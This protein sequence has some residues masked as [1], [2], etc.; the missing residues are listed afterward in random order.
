M[1]IDN[2]KK[3]GILC[4]FSLL[5]LLLNSKVYAEK[6][7]PHKFMSDPE[8]CSQCHIGTPKE[9]IDDYTTVEFKKDIVCFCQDCHQEE[10]FQDLHPLDVRPE[11]TV[12]KDFFLANYS[13]L[14]CITCHDPH[15]KAHAKERYVSVNILERLKS[16]LFF[17]KEFKTYFL[18]RNNSKGELCSSCHTHE[19]IAEG[20]YEIDKTYLEEY[21]GSEK[22]QECHPKIYQ[23]WKKTLHSRFIQDPIE[24]P[25]AVVAKF[26]KDIPFSKNEVVYSIGQHWTQRYI[27]RKDDTLYVRPFIW[28]IQ[29]DQWVS[30]GTYN[31][32]WMK[33]C[34]GCHTT[35][36]KPFVNQYLELGIG[37][38]ACHGPGREHS[39]STDQTDIVNPAKLS[40]ERRDMICESC[41][42]SGHDRSGEFRYPAGYRPGDDLA[43]YY[44][45]LIPLP[46]Q[47]SNTFKGDGSYQDRHNQYLYW[48]TRVN[49]ASG[50]TCDICQ[51]FRMKNPKDGEDGGLVLTSSQICVTCHHEKLERFHEHTKHQLGQVSCR[52]CHIPVI[53]ASRNQYSIHDHRFEFGVPKEKRGTTME[54]QCQNCHPNND[55]IAIRSISP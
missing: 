43:K 29:S 47:P 19:K 37:C 35:A 23:Q 20:I 36:C 55:K 12:P 42:T 49:V 2:R 9:G 13:M 25:K 4:V 15:M 45:G 28:S 7:N 3:L 6:Q 40:S 31:R 5:I 34:A 30:Y 1:K 54:D 11:V 21:T 33:Y 41:H 38:E 50:S 18:R 16:F 27:T 53:A 24:N 44:K 26:T 32:S 46:D 17:E 10:H 8:K 48:Q 52:D 14:T 51:N 22:C 39:I